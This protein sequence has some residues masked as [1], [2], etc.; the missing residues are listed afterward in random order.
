MEGE[1]ENVNFL[2]MNFLDAVEVELIGMNL[3]NWNGL[4]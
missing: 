2:N 3:T 1:I 4:A